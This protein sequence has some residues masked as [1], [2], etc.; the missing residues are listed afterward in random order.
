MDDIAGLDKVHPQKLLSL[1]ETVDT[2][3]IRVIY[4]NI[5]KPPNLKQIIKP[6]NLKQIIALNAN[7]M[8]AL[9]QSL[10]TNQMLR[11]CF[12]VHISKPLIV[13]LNV[14]NLNVYNY[15]SHIHNNEERI[16]LNASVLKNYPYPDTHFY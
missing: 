3:N 1:L 6:P 12:I 4:E 2:R 10:E 11:R 15:H 7:A 14:Q 9:R 16:K 5:T 8:S 13:N